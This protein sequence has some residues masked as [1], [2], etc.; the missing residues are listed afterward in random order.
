MFRSTRAAFFGS[1]EE[2]LYF[3]LP[4]VIVT[5]DSQSEFVG[6]SIQG[7]VSEYLPISPYC[8]GILLHQ[9]ETTRRLFPLVKRKDFFNSILIDGN[10]AF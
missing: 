1:G 4:T 3:H 6:P 10:C 7:G 5:V 9:C 8:E 2:R